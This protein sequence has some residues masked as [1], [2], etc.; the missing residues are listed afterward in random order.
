MNKPIPGELWK[1][2]NRDVYVL[3]LPNDFYSDD[4][5]ITFYILNHPVFGK[6]PATS[7][8]ILDFIKDYTKVS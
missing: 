1:K 6:M 4:Y 2:K 7:T 5:M 8:Y 3:I